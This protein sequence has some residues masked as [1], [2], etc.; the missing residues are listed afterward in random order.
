M[1]APSPPAAPDYP[2][3]AKAQGQANVE[4]ARATGKLNNPN[5]ISPY[6][7][8]TVTYGGGAPSVDQAGY[9]RAL[10]AYQDAPITYTTQ[11]GPAIGSGEGGVIYGPSTQVANPRGIA[12]NIADFTRA[13]GDPD[14]PTVTQ[15]FSPE[16]QGLYDK[17]VQTKGLLGDLGIQGAASL[18]GLIGTPIDYSGAPAAPGDSQ[19]TRDAVIK[20]M[21]SRVNEDTTNKRDQA[22]SDLIARGIRPGTTAYDNAMFSIDRGYNDAR[23]SAILAGGQEA[24]RDFGM[25]TEAR[26]NYIAELLSKRQMPLNEINSLLS[27]SQVNNPFA[28]P[29]FSGSGQV[30][31]A[32]VFGATQAG[33]QY[34][35]DIYNAQVG[36]SNAMQQGAATLGAAGIAAA[37]F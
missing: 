14:V 30:A 8:Q 25:N 35:G 19:S 31:P 4:A 22:N 11:R 28:V 33:S 3:A 7:T 13:S 23:Q 20:A 29:G 36:Q 32:P 2:G 37:F 24:S 27:G 34:A 17:S 9:D 12:P 10:K 26:R 16:Q 21:M 6:G 1:C 15:K 18:K 5:V